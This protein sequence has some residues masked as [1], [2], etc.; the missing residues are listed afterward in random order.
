[1]EKRRIKLFF[2]LG[3]ILALLA[4]MLF[5]AVTF[6]DNLKKEDDVK[7]TSEVQ[8]I[9]SKPTSEKI[10]ADSYKMTVKLNGI[11]Q[12]ITL[13][14]TVEAGKE[15]KI[16]T[17]Y[18]L[19]NKDLVLDLPSSIDDYIVVLN[20]QDYGLSIKFTAQK[21][22]PSWNFSLYGQIGYG[23]EKIAFDQNQGIPLTND[24][25]LT[26]T[27]KEVTGGATI[28]GYFCKRVSE[29]VSEPLGGAKIIYYDTKGNVIAEKTTDNSSDPE[30]KGTFTISGLTKEQCNGNIYAEGPDGYSDSFRV[31]KEE[32]F[33][34]SKY[35]GFNLK[36]ESLAIK[37]DPSENIKL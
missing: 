29:E 21:E 20:K 31:I 1:M 26:V 30:K 18:Y 35:D 14:K 37:L 25:V 9:E 12:G 17:I 33:R 7:A 6:A 28:Q 10:N 13:R 32:D 22:E 16:E 36:S 5:A 19:T 4:I 8:K 27:G 34:D 3:G 24:S 2:A 23:V 15:E 11:S